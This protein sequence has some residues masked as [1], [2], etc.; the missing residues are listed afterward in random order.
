MTIDASNL[1]SVLEDR[2]A[3][4]ISSLLDDRPQTT[5]DDLPEQLA[6]FSAFYDDGQ[7][8]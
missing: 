5:E 7:P 3:R 1:I 8:K 4:A 6:L 2:P